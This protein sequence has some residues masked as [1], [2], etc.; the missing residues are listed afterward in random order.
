M[1]TRTLAKKSPP[2][3]APKAKIPPKTAKR[4]KEEPPE[5]RVVFDPSMMYSSTID[6][7][8]KR[9]EFESTAIEDIPP[10]STGMLSHDLLLGGGIRPSW[11]TSMGAEQSAKTTSMLTIMGSAVSHQIPLVHH[12]DYEGSSASSGKYI[13]EIFRGQGIKVTGPVFGKKGPDGKWEVKPLV[14]YRSETALEAFFNYM[15]AVLSELPD[16]RLVNGKW[17]LIYEDNKVNKAKLSEFADAGM[18][19]RHGAGLWV[20]APDG[21]LQA[22]FCVDSYPAMLPAEQ[23]KEES[24]NSLALQ[25]RAFSKHIPR[26]KGRMAQKMV[27]VIGI[28][29]LRAVPMAMFGPSESEPGGNALKLYS[30]A[31]M[32]HVSRSLSSAPFS[33]KADKDLDFDESEPSTE[34]KGTKDRYRYVHL[35][36]KKNKLSMPG[37]KSW[38]RIWVEDGSGVARGLDPVFDTLQYLKVTGQ[39]SGQR[40]G[41]ILSLDGQPSS[42]S[43]LTWED[44][45]TWIL[46]KREDMVKFSNK[47]GVKPMNLRKF[48]FT[49]MANGKAEQ[50]FIAAERKA[51]MGA[52]EEDDGGSDE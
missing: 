15:H 51:K 39:L 50:L 44:L 34:F 42:K 46:G 25:A 52:K 21:K 41:F 40:K 33:P 11:Y 2:A 14:R 6:D 8:E 38:V 48:C 17:W 29:Q 28:N 1:A 20:P 5:E 26:V 32:K 9:Q 10:M 12:S 30:D 4:V 35:A 49:Q 22:I 45:K 27:A 23:D 7:I 13:R 36:M 3:K 19:K 16:K 31:R 43:K 24:N 18:A 47:A 37:R